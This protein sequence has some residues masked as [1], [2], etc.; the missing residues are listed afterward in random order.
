MSNVND[1]LLHPV[2]AKPALDVHQAACI[3]NDE[4][5]RLGGLE[6]LDLAL[7]H[8]SRKLGVLNGE[9]PAKAAAV[10]GLRQLAEI[11]TA[12]HFQQ[13]ARLAVDSQAAVQ[14]T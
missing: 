5:G 3:T 9:N 14:M 11:R 13:R 12:D 4:R 8:L 1:F 6:V 10:L 7:E 2:A